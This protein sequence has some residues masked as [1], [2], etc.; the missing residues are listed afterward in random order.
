[1]RLAA[2]ALREIC[3]EISRR[4]FYTHLNPSLPFPAPPRERPQGSSLN[5]TDGVIRKIL[6]LLSSD[7]R[8]QGL[9]AGVVTRLRALVGDLPASADHHHHEP[10]GLFRHSLEVALKMLEQFDDQLAGERRP[11]GGI[12]IFQ[13]TRSRCQYISFL[14]GLCHDI[15]K[16]FDMEVQAGG[17]LWS[18]LHCTYEAFRQTANGSPQV[19]WRKDRERGKHATLAI[20]LLHHLLSGLDCYYLGYAG[21]LQLAE[22]LTG[23]HTRDQ[24]NPIAGLVSKLDQESVEEEAPVWMTN[25]PDSKV[26][27]F[28]RVVQALIEQ[29]DL[30]VNSFSAAVYVMGEKTAVVVPLA[31]NLAR[32]LLKQENIALPGNLH[33]Y[34]LLS[35]ARLVEADDC[36]YCVRKIKVIRKQGAVELSALI[37]PTEKIVP[38]RLLPNLPPIRFEIEPDAEQMT[39]NATDPLA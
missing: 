38:K 5:G 3:R 8:V 31:V 6:D 36:G 34:T 11:D 10:G 14:A 22:I 4:I 12:D 32:D 16:V 26:N 15:G 21:I 18:P 13:S 2:G 7:P 20:L 28:L 37:F 9:A 33:L 23:T 17:Q 35:Q 19:I 24:T 30:S 25:Q 27:Q 29:G 1:M 39:P